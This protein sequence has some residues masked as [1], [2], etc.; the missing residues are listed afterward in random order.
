MGFVPGSDLVFPTQQR[1]PETSG[2]FGQFGVLKIVAESLD[3]AKGEDGIVV[4]VEPTNE[5][6]RLPGGERL[7]LGPPALSSPINFSRPR[8]SS[9]SSAMVSR[10]RAL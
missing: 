2:L 6:L 7:P 3:E 4:I 5:F 10:R 1:A 9:R 8:S